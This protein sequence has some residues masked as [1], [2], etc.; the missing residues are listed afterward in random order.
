MTKEQFD[1][2]SE[3]VS[4]V[5]SVERAA[6]ECVM[7]Y[8]L[9]RAIVRAENAAGECFQFI[10]SLNPNELGKSEQP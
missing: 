1:W 7:G 8:E 3:L 4:A 2:F 5:Q 10:G 6:S 9:A